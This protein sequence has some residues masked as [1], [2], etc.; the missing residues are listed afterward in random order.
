MYMRSL[1]RVVAFVACRGITEVAGEF[2]ALTGE[3]VN[4]A[5]L[6]SLISGAVTSY[7]SLGWK[8]TGIGTAATVALLMLTL[9]I[10]LALSSTQWSRDWTRWLLRRCVT[11]AEGARKAHQEDVKART[12]LSLFA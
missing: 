4:D 3:R 5:R 1:D 8:V 6:R 11:T 7:L 2:E 9:A 10:P 12:Q